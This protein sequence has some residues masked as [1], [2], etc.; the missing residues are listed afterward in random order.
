VVEGLDRFGEHF[1]AYT[2]Q[3][4]LIGGAACTLAMDEAGQPFRATKDLD[5]VL[6][7]ESLDARFVESFWEFLRGGDYRIQE[8]ASGEKQFYRFQQPANEGYPF[9]L[10]LFTRAPDAFRLNDETHLTPIP[11]EADVSS[12]SA[13]LLDGDYYSFLQ[14]GKRIISGVP[15][16]GPE[17]LIPLKA[18]AWLDLSHRKADGEQ[19][20]SRNIKKHK[21]DVFRLFSIID[22]EFSA[23]IPPQVKDDLA[24]FIARMAEEEV[25]LKSL[26]LRNETRDNVLAELRRIYGID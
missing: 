25:P 6:C 8:K 14:S 22:P 21:N 5:I 20:D 1:A 10:E 24:A 7:L 13:I 2:D 12:L 17:H 15:I 23:E 3:Y 4:V 11:I 16:V 9:M 19:V 18:K 26:G